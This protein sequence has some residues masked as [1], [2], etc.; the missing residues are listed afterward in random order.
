[1]AEK[2]CNFATTL[3]YSYYTLEGTPDGIHESENKLTVST[4]PDVDFLGIPTPLWL[5][6]AQLGEVN[7]TK[8]SANHI[9][10]KAR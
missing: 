7:F 2:S 3:R 9:V 1:M 8:N 6:H 4:A 10:D 5:S